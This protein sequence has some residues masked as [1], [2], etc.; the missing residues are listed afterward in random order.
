MLHLLLSISGRLKAGSPR[1]KW[2]SSA[3][4]NEKS[5]ANGRAPQIER[6]PASRQ[7]EDYF[8]ISS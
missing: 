1:R 2:R 8:E 3:G 6:M 7:R 5:P 4:N